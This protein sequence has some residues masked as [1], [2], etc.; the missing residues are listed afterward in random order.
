MNNE[1]TQKLQQYKA[2]KVYKKEDNPI[3]KFIIKKFTFQSFS[4][5]FQC[6]TQ[7]YQYKKKKL[8]IFV[9]FPFFALEENK[10]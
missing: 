6:Y 9:L 3:I 8:N 5:K 10:I 2:Y 7:T 1:T 4:L